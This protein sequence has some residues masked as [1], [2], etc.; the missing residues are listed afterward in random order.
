MLTY[1]AAYQDRCF[2]Q[3]VIFPNLLATIG[4]SVCIRFLWN[5]LRLAFGSDGTGF[6]AAFPQ[7]HPGARYGAADAVF[8]TPLALLTLLREKRVRNCLYNVTH[9]CSEPTLYET[10]TLR[11]GAV[12]E[13]TDITA[14]RI[15]VH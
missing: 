3:A 7:S 2:V 14:E 12:E 6:K 13:A 8:A 11:R 1:L 10:D 5:V 9:S 4:K 15:R